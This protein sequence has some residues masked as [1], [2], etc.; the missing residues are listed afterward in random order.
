MHKIVNGEAPSYLIDLL[1]NRTDNAVAYNLRN[2]NDFK[3]PFSRLCS[4]ENS[5]YPSTLKF[6]NELDQ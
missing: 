2:K 6:W 5:Y 4:Y 1:P 3:I